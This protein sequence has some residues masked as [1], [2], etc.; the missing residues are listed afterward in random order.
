MRIDLKL[1]SKI[2]VNLHFSEE[3]AVDCHGYRQEALFHSF[4]GPQLIV[5]ILFE[6]KINF[7]SEFMQWYS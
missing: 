3:L 1:L 4:T 7:T 2:V 6:L 5:T